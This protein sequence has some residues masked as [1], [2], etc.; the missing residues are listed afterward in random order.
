MILDMLSVRDVLTLTGIGVPV[1]GGAFLYFRKRLDKI[2]DNHLVHLDKK[3][4]DVGDKVDTLSSD[5]QRLIGKW[6]GYELPE[7]VT[8]LERRQFASWDNK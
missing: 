2:Q 1:L 3:I 7:R 6:E 4:D 8:R 5:V